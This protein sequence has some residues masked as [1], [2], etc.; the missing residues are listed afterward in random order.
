MSFELWNCYKNP[1]EEEE[2]DEDEENEEVLQPVRYYIQKKSPASSET[3]SGSS[4]TPKEGSLQAGKYSFKKFS[5]FWFFPL[6][7]AWMTVFPFGPLIFHIKP[8]TIMRDQEFENK[9]KFLG[10]RAENFVQ[11]Y[12]ALGSKWFADKEFWLGH[13]FLRNNIDEILSE[14]LYEDLKFDVD[15]DSIS[16]SVYRNKILFVYGDFMNIAVKI[17]PRANGTYPSLL[18]TA[19]YDSFYS[20]PGAGDANFVGILLEILRVFCQAIP[21][22]FVSYRSNLIFLFVGARYNH[23][24]SIIH[25]AMD[26]KWRKDIT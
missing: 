13:E 2:D 4:I 3:S 21:E 17:S 26:H 22:K 10:Y 1:S 15:L 14:T 6:T 9:D 24:L 12:T 25:F 11:Q 16:G 8:L 19:N 5:V 20:S 18:V 23:R 7:L